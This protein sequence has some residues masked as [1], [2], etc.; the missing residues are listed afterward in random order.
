M[1]PNALQEIKAFYDNR[2]PGYDSEGGLHIKQ[3]LDYLK[4]MSPLPGQKI[5][6]LACGTGGITL[7][8]KKAV[9]PTGKVIGV[10]I[11]GVSLS[12]ARSKAEKEGLE[13]KFIEHDIHTVHE[14]GGIEEGNFDIIVCAAALVLLKDPGAAVKQWAKLLKP[15]GMLITDVLTSDTMVKGILLDRVAEELGVET[16]HTRAKLDTQE[17]VLALLTDAGLEAKESFTTE[18]YSEPKTL[19]V[20]NAEGIFD[21]LFEDTPVRRT[22]YAELL[23]PERREKAKEIFVREMNKVAGPDGKVVEYVRFHMAIGRKV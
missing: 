14:L 11:S 5:L 10:D 15:A 8:A 18:S 13:I 6:D 23:V 22:W 19:D 3:A 20:E 12:I 7:P 16:V 4:W 1:S 2:A 17:K 21:A 9:G